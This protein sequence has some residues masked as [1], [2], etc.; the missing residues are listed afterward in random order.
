MNIPII[1]HKIDDILFTVSS[2]H[3][4]VF[5]IYN[6]RIESF[7]YMIH[8]EN[9]ND[10]IKFH[11]SR[12]KKIIFSPVQ[13]REV[14]HIHDHFLKRMKPV[15]ETILK[16][17]VKEEEIVFITNYH[18]LLDKEM[19]QRYF[20]ARIDILFLR[21]FEIDAVLRHRTLLHQIPD[22]V[23]NYQKKY[24][25]LFGKT[26]KFMRSGALIKMHYFEMINDAIYSSLATGIEI[27]AT[28]QQAKMYW[29]EKDLDLVLH[30]YS[31]TPDEVP[32]V[33]NGDSEIHYD[34]YPYDRSIYQNTF[35]SILAET[36]DIQ[37]EDNIATE[38]FFITEKFAR[39]IFNYHPFVILSTPYF[40]KNIKDLGYCTFDYVIDESYDNIV[41]PYERLDAALE[42]ARNFPTDNRKILDSVKHN[43][44]N[45]ND[46]YSSDYKK[47]KDF[48]ER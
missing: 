19:I 4:A 43:F 24:L 10:I 30:K 44:K 46:T 34:G 15:M 20:N 23:F 32:H 9:W 40:L 22:T 12:C 47:L 5:E 14:G 35:C 37:Y 42:S 38:Q 11:R 21:Y 26:R 48:L 41:D 29:D 36:N 31:G 25:S 7:A 45:I 18:T 3:F 28:I 8:S 2:N 13:V 1:D 17:G 16:L 27:Q 33:S 39:A 6:D